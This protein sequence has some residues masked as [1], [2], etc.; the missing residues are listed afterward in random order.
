MSTRTPDPHAHQQRRPHLVLCAKSPWH[1]ALRREHALAA[2]AAL[3]GFDVDFVEAPGDV[4][5][6]PRRSHPVRPDARWVTAGDA[7]A[8][9]VWSRWTPVPGHRGAL[10]ARADRAGLRRLLRR[11][12][13]PDS[14][15]C[16][17]LPWQWGAADSLGV[18]TVFDAADDW[19]AL[20][21][22]AAARLRPQ[23]AAVAA[24]ADAVVV[25][26]PHLASLFPGAAVR[27]V[28]NGAPSALLDAPIA[29]DGD[30]AAARRMVYVGTLSERLDLGLLTAVLRRLPDWSLDL[31][32]H[33][34]FAG[35]RDAPSPALQHF[36][37]EFAPRARWR[38][39]VPRSEVAAVLDGAT[40]GVIPNR[41]DLAHGQSSMK[42][43]DYAARGLPVVSTELSPAEA[44]QAPPGVTF[45]ADADCFVE[46]LTR[47]AADGRGQAAA[48]REWAAHRTWTTRW[49]EWT[50]AAGARLEE[51]V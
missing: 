11:L 49:S 41:S 15:V 50:R 8:V 36:L 10:A 13:R 19:T 20:V 16:L 23:Y 48:M 29:V 32:G 47:A 38:G 12:V 46:A 37:D 24:G 45:A 42:L 28:P 1:P 26:T 25:V 2:Q 5:D 51:T 31:Y 30:P 43:L 44:A 7:A 21:P 3:A 35:L 14:L 4:R 27:V 6:L 9:R 17:T 22:A 18:R 40:V 34:A 33:C 39:G